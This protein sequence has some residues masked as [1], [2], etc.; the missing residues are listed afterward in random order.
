[1]Q[2]C[3]PMCSQDTPVSEVEGLLYAVAVVNVDVHVQHA[4]RHG[5][6]SDWREKVQQGGSTMK[7]PAVSMH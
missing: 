3:P 5:P 7:I 4:G 6:R 2:K 1:M